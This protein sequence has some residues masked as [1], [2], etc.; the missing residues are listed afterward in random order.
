MAHEWS[1]RHP[2]ASHQT[3]RKA[4]QQIWNRVDSRL[5]QVVYDRLFVHNVAKNVTQALVRAPGWTG[6]TIL[7]VGGGLKDIAAF[8]KD[9]AAGKKPE[10]TDRA[11]YTISLLLIT[12]L[13]NAILTAAFAGEPPD[14]WKDLLA[15]RTGRKDE[16]GNPE[17][18]MLPTYAKDLYSYAQ[19]PGTTL[20]HKSHP[21]LS[22]V[23]DIAR[24]KDFYGTEI[25]HQGDNPAMQLV[26]V[27]KFTAK[28][29]IPFWM[30]G[31]AKE[32]ERG[33]NIASMAAPLIGIM[34]APAA[35]NQTKAEQL[36]SRLVAD[37]MPQGTKTQEQF[38]R[39]QT[40]QRLTGLARRDR[41]QAAQEIKEALQEKKI[42]PIQAK[43]IM[44]NARLTPIQ[45]SFKRLS[46]E[47]AQRVYEV[48]TEEEKKL[49]RPMFAKKRSST[50][51]NMW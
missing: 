21:M 37:R 2:N 31:A 51:Q 4:M 29:F 50:Q 44:Q 1:K 13:A 48:A 30:K 7:E 24:N 41:A 34:P 16:K 3:T 46:Y 26:Q 28:A 9:A 38:E 23:G 19:K 20:L 11:A 8:A 10:L 18:F 6:G 35:L 14:D 12:A 27:G 25:R 42:T 17:R 22:L 33:G 15:F 40:A 47:E 43:H 36:A 39:S 5:G 49:L 45:V 32:I